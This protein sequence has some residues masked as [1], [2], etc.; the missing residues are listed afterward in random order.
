MRSKGMIRSAD[1]LTR[2]LI[3]ERAAILEFDAGLARE[4]AE[5]QAAQMNGFR[6][7]ADAMGETT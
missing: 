3:E 1:E 6:N 5:H 7:W 2:D 4:E